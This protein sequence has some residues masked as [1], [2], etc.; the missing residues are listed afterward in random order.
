MG[1]RS[2]PLTLAN[3]KGNG[4]PATDDL[5][6][7]QGFLNQA[8]AALGVALNTR[9][10]NL[11]RDIERRFER[12]EDTRKTETEA[13]AAR[14]LDTTRLQSERC[15]ALMAPYQSLGPAFTLAG[16]IGRH[17]KIA[18]FVASLVFALAV[19]IGGILI[20]GR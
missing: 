17:P 5:V 13:L 1:R 14:V 18:S 6:T 9:I 19:A 3:A 12:M 15:V 2:S 16:M 11:D 20:P 4:V 10:D 7:V 8:V